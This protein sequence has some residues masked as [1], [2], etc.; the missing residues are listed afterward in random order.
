[1]GNYR[2]RDEPD[3][4]AIP[5]ASRSRGRYVADSMYSLVEARLRIGSITSL[6]GAYLGPAARCPTLPAI[7]S[8]TLFAALVLHES[9]DCLG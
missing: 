2:R 1:M 5:A 9:I 7:R 6:A 3:Y 8:L 4:P